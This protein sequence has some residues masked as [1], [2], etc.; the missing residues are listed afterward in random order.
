M[1]RSNKSGQLAAG[2]HNGAAVNSE[3]YSRQF[4]PRWLNVIL[5]ALCIANAIAL[6]GLVAV[7]RM[8]P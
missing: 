4:S 3:R 6:V 1:S 7:I 5:V 8:Y 2:I